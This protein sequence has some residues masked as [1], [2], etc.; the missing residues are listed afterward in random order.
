MGDAGG[1]PRDAAPRRGCHARK[2]GLPY[3]VGIH[4]TS[5]SEGYATRA[6]VGADALSI[7]LVAHAPFESWM[8]CARIGLADVVAI[9]ERGAAIALKWT[10]QGRTAEVFLRPIT[11]ADRRR[12]LWELAVR[13][14]DAMERG[15]APRV[16]GVAAGGTLAPTGPRRSD[17]A[18][19]ASASVA[20][21][22][23]DA[24]MSSLATGLAGPDEP[25]RPAP[26]KSGLGCGLFAAGHAVE[27]TSDDR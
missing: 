7:E 24:G 12:L 10:A 16:P 11:Y 14:P 5:R 26:P 13:C 20:M 4:A 1:E 22:G 19:V 9:R 27:K 23:L 21:S 3:S 8:P 6:T 25:K 2:L 15:L 18:P 17:P